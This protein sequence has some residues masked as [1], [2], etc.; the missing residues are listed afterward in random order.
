MANK[1]NIPPEVL[2]K[3]SEIRR[4]IREIIE[5]LQAKLGPKQA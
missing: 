4:D 5:F 2:E 1:K 3:L